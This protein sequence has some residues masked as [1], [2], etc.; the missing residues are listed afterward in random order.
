MSKKSSQCLKGG[1]T[2]LR[3]LGL[4]ILEGNIKELNKENAMQ[5]SHIVFKDRPLD[6]IPAA[7]L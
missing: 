6:M 1:D 4:F 3:L 2:V 5:R 7:E